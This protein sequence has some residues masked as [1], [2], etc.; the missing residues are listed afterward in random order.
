MVLIFFLRLNSV[1]TGQIFVNMILQNFITTYSTSYC[2]LTKFCTYI[3]HNLR[4]LSVFKKIT[5]SPPSGGKG[6]PTLAA[7]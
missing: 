1:P 7:L 2:H 6:E 3:T 5:G 4:P